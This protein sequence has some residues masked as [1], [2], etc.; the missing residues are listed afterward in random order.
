M[1]SRPGPKVTGRLDAVDLVKVLLRHGANPN[2]RLK[3]PI[4]GRHHDSGD[5]SLGEGTTPLIRAAKTVD[6][7]V[8][9][10]LLEGGADAGITQKD[11]TTTVMIA[12]AGGRGGVAG[13]S[14]VIE[15][16]KLCLDHGVDVDAFNTAGQT[17][18]HVAAGRGADGVI[19]LLAERGAK[20]DMKNRQNRTPL[21]LASGAGGAGRGGPP[22][23]RQSTVALLRQL[24][25]QQ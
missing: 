22:V 15:A 6:V 4:I 7:A 9:R 25:G 5:P 1:L 12:A 11:Y 8:M 21:D 23:V 14:A 13:E 16:V 20:L 10:V 19:R 3:R 2:A 17:A 24:M 18:L